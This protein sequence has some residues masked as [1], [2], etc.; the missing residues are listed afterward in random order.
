LLVKSVAVWTIRG[1]DPKRYG[2]RILDVVDAH[3]KTVPVFKNLSLAPEVR[4]LLAQLTDGYFAVRYG[5]AH[6]SYDDETWRLF[7]AV[8]EQLLAAART[9]CDTYQPP[10]PQTDSG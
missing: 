4:E 7:C 6:V 9:A 10:N 3:A 1:F 8:A 5:E 2:H